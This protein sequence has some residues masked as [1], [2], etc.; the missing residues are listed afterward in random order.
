[1][2][3]DGLAK[4]VFLTSEDGQRGAEA[5]EKRF[6]HDSGFYFVKKSFSPE[7]IVFAWPNKYF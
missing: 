6:S 4:A 7:K 5:E 1:L 3:L 2:L